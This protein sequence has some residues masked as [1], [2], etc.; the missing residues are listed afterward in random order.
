MFL[1]NVLQYFQYPVFYMLMPDELGER[2]LQKTIYQNFD[3][4]AM[5]LLNTLFSL[6]G[7]SSFPI[8]HRN[9]LQD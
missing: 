4:S 1:Q 8:E 5:L 7:I 2:L 3:Q 6:A 9:I